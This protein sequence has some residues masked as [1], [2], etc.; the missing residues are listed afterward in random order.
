M[1]STVGTLYLIGAALLIIMI[2]GLILIVAKVL[3]M[4]AFFSLPEKLP[5]KPQ[6]SK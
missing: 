6:N 4:I 3:E 1:F 2:G 5:T